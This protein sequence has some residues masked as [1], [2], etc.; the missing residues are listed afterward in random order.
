MASIWEYGMPSITDWELLQSIQDGFDKALGATESILRVK[1]SMA[2]P[3][4]LSAKF[5]YEVSKAIHKSLQDG[6]PNRLCLRVI[7]VDE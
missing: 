5:V 6:S 2:G 7:K 3:G 1:T 4:R